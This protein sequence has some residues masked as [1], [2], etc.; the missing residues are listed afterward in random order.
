[1]EN[2]QVLPKTK[3]DSNSLPG[4]E[5][6]KQWLTRHNHRCDV[7]FP[8]HHHR[9]ARALRRVGFTVKTVQR[10]DDHPGWLLSL[11][12]GTVGNWRES[13][14]VRR[15][16]SQ[17][18]RELGHRC[19]PRDVGCFINGQV[20]QVAFGWE[21]GAPGIVTFWSPNRARPILEH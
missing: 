18:L 5:T 6:V 19:P 16:V 11:R 12:P 15:L 21:K 14:V 10:S 9:L 8:L 1:M 7:G 17:A 3:S 4:D 2:Q 20:L 13:K